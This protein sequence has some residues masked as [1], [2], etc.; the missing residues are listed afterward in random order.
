MTRTLSLRDYSIGLA[1]LALLALMVWRVP[2]WAVVGA[3][4]MAGAILG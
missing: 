3:C 2:P 1:L 4:A